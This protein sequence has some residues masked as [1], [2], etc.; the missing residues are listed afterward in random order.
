VNYKNVI[1][2][3]LLAGLGVAIL[4]RL[5]LTSLCNLFF[6]G[7]LWVGSI[8][9]VWHYNYLSTDEEGDR[10]PITWQNGMFVGFLTGFIAALVGGIIYYYSLT[11]IGAESLVS[12]A[13]ELMG[14]D[15]TVIWESFP[16]TGLSKEALLTIFDLVFNLILYPVIG[17]MGGII[18]V[19]L[20]KRRKNQE[21]PPDTQ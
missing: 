11:A 17:S 16:T 2:S 19:S 4:S 21:A 8:F 18:G 1:L 15:E 6:C 5:P 3:S 7:W 10:E 9:S 13:G 20:F 12:R 14:I